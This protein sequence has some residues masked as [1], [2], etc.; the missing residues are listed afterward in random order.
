MRGDVASVSASVLVVTGLIVAL[1]VGFII[2]AVFLRGKDYGVMA[3]VAAVLCIILI[4][5]FVRAPVAYEL[6]GDT[7]TIEL[8]VG[9]RQ[10]GPIASCR[11]ADE[12]VSFAVR[13]WGN[14]GLFAVT[15]LYRDKAHGSFRAFVTDPKRLVLVQTVSDEKIVISPSNTAEWVYSR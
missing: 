9:S 11:P 3:I 1:A 15:G 8:R 2:A 14:G 10:F 7:L 13:V 5:A 12:P 6:N 4:W